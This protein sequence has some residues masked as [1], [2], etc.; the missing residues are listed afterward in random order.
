MTVEIR[1][2]I[3]T[4]D[5]HIGKGLTDDNMQDIGCCKDSNGI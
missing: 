4:D 5:F 1:Q 3:L 2:I